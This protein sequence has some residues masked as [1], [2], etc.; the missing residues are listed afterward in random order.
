M[1]VLSSFVL[2]FHSLEFQE[3]LIIGIVIVRI[4]SSIP[5]SDTPFSP[6]HRLNV[7]V[8]VIVA[9]SFRIITALAI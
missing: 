9:L 4:R 1:P 6:T 8:I 3:F 5:L 7:A 2:L